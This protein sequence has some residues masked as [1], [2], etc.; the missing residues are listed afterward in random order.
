MS[1][2]QLER[3]EEAWTALSRVI[4]AP[5]NEAE[6]DQLVGIADAIVDRIGEEESHPLAS[7]LDVIGEL[8]HAYEESHGSFQPQ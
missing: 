8:I 2:A 3:L 4:R 7:L 1:T 5:R 6:Y